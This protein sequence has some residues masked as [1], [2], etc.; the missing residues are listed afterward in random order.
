MS[1]LLSSSEDEDALGVLDMV[2]SAA[3]GQN[4]WMN[5]DRVLKPRPMPMPAM[6]GG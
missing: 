6:R 1:R 4:G 3:E 2:G 5:S